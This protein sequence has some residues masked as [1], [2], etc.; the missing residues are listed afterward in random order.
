MNINQHLFGT[1]LQVLIFTAVAALLVSCRPNGI[2]SEN[3]T[4]TNADT[5]LQQQGAPPK[6]TLDARQPAPSQTMESPAT[7]P[8]SEA[9][10]SQATPQDTDQVVIA[11]TPESTNNDPA[12]EN[13]LPAIDANVG[14]RAPD[15]E[16]TAITGE[17]LRLSNFSGQYVI[18][19]YW[20]SWCIPCSRELKILQSYFSNP[21]D[22]DLVILT[23]N[24]IE[25][26]SL[27]GAQE[28]ISELGLTFPVILDEGA[29]IWETYRVLFLPT[30][31]FIDKD[32]VIRYIKLGEF[33]EAEF[34]E[35][36]DKLVSNQLGDLSR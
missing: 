1:Y 21:Q 8:T 23:I 33:T 12:A 14:F 2:L 16:L 13:N 29:T 3:T 10:E 5:L 30:T 6:E 24:G 20:T 34:H 7:V 35:L 36:K 26:D 4:A 31:F 25:Q 32:G 27:S 9:T 19:N 17:S 15:F 22:E 28:M 18:L 11:I